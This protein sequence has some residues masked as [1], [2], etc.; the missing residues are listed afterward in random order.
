MEDNILEVKNLTK[1]FPV[2]GGSLKVQNRYVKAVDDVSFAIKRGETLSMVGESGCGK[3]T[4]G[5]CVID[6]IKPT[7]GIVNFNGKNLI[8]VSEKERRELTGKMQ[9]IFQDPYMSLNPRMTIG[10]IVEEPLKVHGI[11][12][13]RTERMEMAMDMLEKV[14][15]RPDQ[16]YR[17][18]HGFSGGQKQRI[19]IARAL[20]LKPE[21]VVCD[22][23]VSALDVSIQSQVL[24]L[25]GQ[26]K[27]DL[28]ITYLFISHNMSVVR[29]VSDRIAVMYLG[30]IVELAETE[31]LFN[32]PIHPYTKALLSAVPEV[33]IH[34]K[35]EPIVLEGEIPS[36]LN[37]PQGCVFH[38]R[39][40][41][42]KPICTDQFPSFK[43]RSPGHFVS[44]FRS[45]EFLLESKIGRKI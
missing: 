31:E 16:Y 24:N 9:M 38:N 33:D 5:R 42:C 1:Y 40:K 37:P 32:N 4:T 14:G 8:S 29:Y 19:G 44:C 41:Y 12:K 30:H 27:K 13:N 39:C 43:E 28:G 6:L 23:P 25:L 10:E 22:E 2:Q 17:Y 7:S 15:M 21:L 11:G 35:K 18:P 45:K 3:S 26:M 20:I 36:P 34:T